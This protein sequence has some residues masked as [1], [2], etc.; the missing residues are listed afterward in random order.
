MFSVL[1]DSTSSI[2]REFLLSP[3]WTWYWPQHSLYFDPYLAE[4]T[5]WKPSSVHIQA[6]VLLY[7]THY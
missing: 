5:A 1:W 6:Y 3:L 4:S 7:K 2:L